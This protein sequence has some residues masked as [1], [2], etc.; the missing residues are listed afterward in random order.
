MCDCR[1]GRVGAPRPTGPGQV[2]QAAGRPLFEY[3]GP[4][5]LTVF[6]P[7]SGRRYRF[8]GPGATLAVDPRDHAALHAVPQLRAR[9]Q[10]QALRT[11]TAGS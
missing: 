11:T 1:K 7:A 8:G 6:G 3:V 5:A 4:T 10:A 9:L 2:A